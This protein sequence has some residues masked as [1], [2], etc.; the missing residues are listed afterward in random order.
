M[1]KDLLPEKLVL[2][3]YYAFVDE[4]DSLAAY[5]KE[6]DFNEAEL[7]NTLPANTDYSIEK[8]AE[9]N[10]NAKWESGFSPIKVNDFV[11]VRASFHAAQSSVE[12]DLIIT[13]KMSFGTGHHATTYMML[14]AMQHIDFSNKSVIDFGAG[15]GVLAILA[16]KMGA[17]NV[18]AIDNDKWSI[19]NIHE[20]IEVNNCQKIVVMHEDAIPRENHANIILANITLNVLSQSS[21]VIFNSLNKDGFLLIS[22][23]LE[24][25]MSAI[26]RV[27]VK[28]RYETV[29]VYQREK[30]ACILYRRT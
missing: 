15:T 3:N 8:I 5:I 20:N 22:G 18:L 29:A 10:W 6:L 17:E 24:T 19:E 7:K 26:N 13:P 23:I 12:Y 14:A 27:F 21:E 1:E 2:I 11:A 25:D 16:A 28:E 4:G 9:E 30:W